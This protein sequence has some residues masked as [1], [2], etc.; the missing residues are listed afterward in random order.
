MSEGI[1]SDSSILL[2]TSLPGLYA[3][4]CVD[5]ACPTM[6]LVV[7]PPPSSPAL[8]GRQPGLGSWPETTDLCLSAHFALNLERLGPWHMLAAIFVLQ[9]P[10][11]R[12]G[13]VVG[14]AVGARLSV[15][16]WV[17]AGL[18]WEPRGDSVAGPVLYTCITSIV[19]FWASS[20]GALT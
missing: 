12:P 7:P 10:P 15:P 6:D 4:F 20:S 5:D 19:L 9:A 17:S 3:L 8:V 14:A 1:L 11:V 13:A 16:H 2:R 18:R